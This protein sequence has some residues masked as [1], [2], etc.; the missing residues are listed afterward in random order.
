MCFVS[1]FLRLFGNCTLSNCVNSARMSVRDDHQ[2]NIHC[3]MAGMMGDAIGFILTEEA[4][5]RP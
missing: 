5:R 2:Q 4:N 1:G 3:Q